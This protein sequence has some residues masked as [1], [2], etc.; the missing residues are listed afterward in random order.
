MS[1]LRKVALAVIVAVCLLLTI[2][3]FYLYLSITRR[4]YVIE[5]VASLKDPLAPWAQV[6]SIAALD[7]KVYVSLQQGFNAG[8]AGCGGIYSIEYVSLNDFRIQL[9]LPYS[10]AGAWW[11]NF[12]P[13]SAIGG[14]WGHF[15]QNGKLYFGGYGI[16]DRNA[17]LI[18][19]PDKNVYFLPDGTYEIWSMTGRQDKLYV[20]TSFCIFYTNNFIEWRKLEGTDRRLGI[21]ENVVWGM[22][23]Y[24][25]TLF[26]VSNFLYKYD[27]TERKFII[28][29][30]EVETP[31][32][33]PICI[34]RNKLWFSGFAALLNQTY[35]WLISYD[36]KTGAIE[37]FK[38]PVNSVIDI[39]A[40]SNNLWLVGYT[41][42]RFL[43]EYM[44][45]KDGCLFRFDGDSFE[46][47]VE[48]KN[49]G[50]FVGL[51]GLG[52]YIYFGTFSGD[53]YRVKIN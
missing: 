20:A 40:Y 39:I 18:S 2:F 15:S 22:V 31:T 21:D 3:D 27:E 23:I 19:I 30:Y 42:P 16:N 33:K 37:K 25:E 50:G 7:N 13:T 32:L 48:I 51:A 49:C 38:M 44:H 34:W 12:P 17:V 43:G 14:C 5:F 9:E 46:K 28:L 26:A 24:N 47:V 10:A 4:P 11:C 6:F 53:V 36:P 45:G 35:T 41:P 8:Y 29:H 52:D 1:V